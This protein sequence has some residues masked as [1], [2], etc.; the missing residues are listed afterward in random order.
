MITTHMP[1]TQMDYKC[2]LG[3]S[4][5]ARVRT[6]RGSARSRTPWRWSRTPLDG[7]VK[8]RCQVIFFTIR[9]KI[10]GAGWEKFFLMTMT[11]QRMMPAASVRMGEVTARQC[12]VECMEAHAITA[13]V[14][15]AR[16]GK[17]SAQDRSN[18]GRGTGKKRKVT[19]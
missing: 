18:A 19:G 8:S 14:R 6:P 9:S 13:R 1:R 3:W 16:H 2:E 10:F 7:Q 4:S 17:N 12:D 15:V 5:T 11:Y